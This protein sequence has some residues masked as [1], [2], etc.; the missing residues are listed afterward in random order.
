MCAGDSPDVMFNV[1][2]AESVAVDV[3]SV[4]QVQYDVLWRPHV[5]ALKK[6]ART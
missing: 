4:V 2:R 5:R 1:P 6:V 3:A